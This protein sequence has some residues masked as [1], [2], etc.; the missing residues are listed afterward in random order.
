MK[1]KMFRNTM[2]GNEAEIQAT[3]VNSEETGSQGWLLD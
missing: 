2:L 3:R 1:K